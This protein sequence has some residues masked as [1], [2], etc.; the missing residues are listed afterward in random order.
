MYNGVYVDAVSTL[1]RLVMD[2]SDV[3]RGL[4]VMIYVLAKKIKLVYSRPR[5]LES[6][7]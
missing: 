7:Y 5:K 4:I 2:D 3:G 1:I 6:H